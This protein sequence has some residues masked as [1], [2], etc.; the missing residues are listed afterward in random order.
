ML[1]C[2]IVIG[3]FVGRRERR[4]ST[5]FLM[6]LAIQILKG[7]RPNI[8]INILGE[9]TFIFLLIILFK[10]I[11]ILCTSAKHKNQRLIYLTNVSAINVLL[12]SIGIKS[13][14]LGIVSRE[15]IF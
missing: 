4:I 11:H 14:T 7:I 9:L 3:L 6:C 2:L 1:L 8:L 12:Q 5:D 10:S 13:F 15:T